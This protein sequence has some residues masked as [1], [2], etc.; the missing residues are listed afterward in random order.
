M[1]MAA[2]GMMMGMMMAG[3]MGG[4]DSPTP[5]PSVPAPDPTAADELATEQSRNAKLR[6]KLH[7]ETLLTGPAGDQLAPEDTQQPTLL[8]A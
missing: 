2:V 1:A 7:G 6:K 8:G 5:E 4:D 3:M